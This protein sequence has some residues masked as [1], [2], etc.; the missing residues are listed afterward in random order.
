MSIAVSQD[1]Y[2]DSK[3]CEMELHFLPGMQASHLPHLLSS[4]RAGTLMLMAIKRLT[5]EVEGLLVVCVNL[6][7][8]E[9]ERKKGGTK[10]KERKRRRTKGRGVGVR[11]G[12]EE[13][14]L[15]DRMENSAKQKIGYL[16]KTGQVCEDRSYGRYSKGGEIGVISIISIF[17]LSGGKPRTEAFV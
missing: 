15:R 2:W 1:F 3:G 6:P 16:L 12:R 8:H 4:N 14:K 7:W 9:I 13:K 17:F 10:G 5:S 11:G